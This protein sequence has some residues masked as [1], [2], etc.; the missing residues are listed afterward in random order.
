M[1]KFTVL[2]EV[3]VGGNS[4]LLKIK[5][6]DGI[7]WETIAELGKLLRQLIH[8]NN[9]VFVSLLLTGNFPPFIVSFF[10]QSLFFQEPIDKH[11]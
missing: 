10:K 4:F 11:I 1:N 6:V 7:L 3:H 9:S 2:P 5:N 8:L